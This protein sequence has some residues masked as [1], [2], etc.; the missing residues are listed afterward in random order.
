[1]C[2]EDWLLGKAMADLTMTPLQTTWRFPSCRDVLSILDPLAS[3]S[4]PYNMPAKPAE[5]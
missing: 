3:W 4:L 5:S 2:Q 1:M